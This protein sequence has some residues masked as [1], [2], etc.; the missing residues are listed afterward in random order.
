M[1]N[2]LPFLPQD[3]DDRYFQAAPKDQWLD[4]LSPGMILVVWG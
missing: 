1:E 2:V 4:K 3:F